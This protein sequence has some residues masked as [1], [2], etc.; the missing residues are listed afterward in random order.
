LWRG[1]AKRSYT[2]PIDSMSTEEPN[3]MRRRKGSGTEDQAPNPF[4]ASSS[5]MPVGEETPIGSQTDALEQALETS[6]QHEAELSELL[7]ASRAIL[8]HREFEPVARAIFDTCKRLTGATAGYVALLSGDGTDNEVLFL[9]AG[10]A[11]CT[12][13]PSLPMPIRGLRELVYRTGNTVY[14]NDFSD[15]EWVQYLPPGH[16]DIQNVLFAPLTIQGIVVG[17]LGLANKPGGFSERDRHM[18]TLLGE[19]AAIALLNNRALE[20]LEHS[21]ERFRAVAQTANDAIISIDSAG[22]IVFWND[23]AATIFGFSGAEMIGQPLSRVMPERYR[24]DH[25]KGLERVVSTGASRIIGKTIEMVGLGKDGGEVPIELSL[26]KWTSTGE[27]FFTG[28]VRDTTERKRALAEIQSLAQFP[29]ENRNPVLR[30]SRKGTVL[31]ANAASAPVLAAWNSQVGQKLPEDWLQIIADVSGCDEHRTVQIECAE[32]TFALDVTPVKGAEYV[33]LYGRDVTAREQAEE[34]LR[35]QNEFITTVFESLA[36]PFYV[37]DADDYTIKM[38]NSATYPSELSKPVACYTLTHG[39]RK[40]CGEEGHLCPLEEIKKTGRPVVAEHVHYNRQGQRRIY[41]V[42]GHPIFDAAGHV[43]QIIE[44][45][46][47]ITERKQAEEALEQTS[48][49]LETIL[50]HTPALMAYLDPQFN[51]IRVN[52]A[53]AEADGRERS[54]FPGRNHFDLFPHPQNEAIF[55]RVVETAEPCFEYAKRFEHLENPEIGVHYWDW[56]LVPIQDSAGAVAGLI[57]T[58][59]DVTERVEAESALQKERDF[60]SAVLDT[61]GALVVVL[62]TQGRIVRFNRACEKLTGYAFDEVKGQPFW[63]LFLVPE[64]MGSVRTIF[65]ELQAGELPNKHENYWLTRDGERRLIAW[66]NTGLIDSEGCVEHVIGTGIDITERRRAEEA[67]QQAHGALEQRVQERTAE[68]AKANDELRVV[69]AQNAKLYEAELQARQTAETLSTASLALTRTLDLDTVITT[70]LDYLYSVVPY[71]SACVLLPQDEGHLVVRAAR[72]YENWMDPQE[73]L[74]SIIATRD[75]PHIHRVLATQQSVLI[76]DTHIDPGWMPCAEREHVANWLGVPLVASDKV[77]GICGF[78]KTEAGFFTQEHRQLAEALIGEAAV[79][80][81]NA[82][83]FQQVRA[84]RERLQALSKRLVEAQE[85]ERRYIARELHDEA[86]QALSSLKVG[87]QLLGSEAERPEGVIA[88]VSELQRMVDSVIEG[89]HRL[90]VDLR[91][92]SLDHIGLV[93]ALRQ[94]AQAVS[95]QHDLVVQFEAVGSI[96][97]LSSDFETALYRVVQEALTNVIRHAQATRADVLLEQRGDKLIVL[98]EDNG[99]GFDPTMAKQA[100]HLGLFGIRERAEMLGGTLLLESSPGSGTTLI[101][102]VPY[103][104]AVTHRR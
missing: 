68:L 54:F 46:L 66:S 60:T 40:P 34:L 103:D 16:A 41:E 27:V 81:Q 49:L 7:S 19:L 85:S 70:L 71:D 93:A 4:P 58:L 55:R 104:N 98:V 44:Y 42:R 36:H 12:V 22:K 48:K 2:M 52:Q 78:D 88:G 29:S 26:S 23:G 5:G 18:A 24:G 59:S 102:E 35:A 75:V 91:P 61:A 62:D 84:G 56:S 10:G 83:L 39:R 9:D 80:V 11:P 64:E 95:D 47:D 57:L 99:V 21:E 74:G 25:Q 53:Y 6:R 28:I 92:A 1:R 73:L 30:V 38:A 77:I 101:L 86:G 96:E 32:R 89:L 63:D 37:I 69:A 90:A 17:L 31:Y 8:S 3:D 65:R 50:E 14:E 87:L 94:Y 72:G 100:G 20:A 43:S 76:P 45:T 51:F 67:L 15:T 33:N 13:D 79:A 97:R 82:W